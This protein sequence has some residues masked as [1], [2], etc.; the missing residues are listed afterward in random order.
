MKT[1]YFNSKNQEIIYYNYIINY[2]KNYK[3]KISLF[4]NNKFISDFNNIMQAKLYIQKN[5]IILNDL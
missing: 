2:S 1:N 5:I 4:Y 3:N